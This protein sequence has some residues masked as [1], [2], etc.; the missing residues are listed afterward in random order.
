MTY[1]HLTDSAASHLTDDL[2]VLNSQTAKSAKSP[3][4]TR[5]T[6]TIFNRVYWPVSFTP[7]QTH[8]LLYNAVHR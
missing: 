7:P 5:T 4:E 1:I 2:A 3:F 6:L 8:R